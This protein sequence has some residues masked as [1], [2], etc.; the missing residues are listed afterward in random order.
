MKHE[1]GLVYNFMKWRDAEGLIS[2]TWIKT[3]PR[4]EHSF[5]PRSERNF[6]FNPHDIMLTSRI[7]KISNLYIFFLTDYSPSVAG[8]GARSI[9]TLSYSYSPLEL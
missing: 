3:N 9:G 5:K 2:W 6:H 4:P 1:T 8:K 7:Q